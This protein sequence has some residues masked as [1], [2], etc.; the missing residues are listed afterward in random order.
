MK[1]VEP[2]EYM[3]QYKPYKYG[4]L[5]RERL[6]CHDVIQGVISLKLFERQKVES[7]EENG[8]GK[9]KGKGGGGENQSDLV[10]LSKKREI[11]MR[12]YN[13]SNLI[14]HAEGRN[15]VLISNLTL[16][17]TNEEGKEMD[18]IIEARFDL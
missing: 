2:L 7:D 4:V 8:G 11:I 1:V 15:E 17:P 5:F 13:G 9:G 6:F 12:I 16:Q 18:Y 14:Y 10:E 3:D